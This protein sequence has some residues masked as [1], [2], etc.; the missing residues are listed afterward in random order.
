M[1]KVNREM[2]A[3]VAKHGQVSLPNGSHIDEFYER[4]EREKKNVVAQA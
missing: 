3:A 1:D 4:I 2:S